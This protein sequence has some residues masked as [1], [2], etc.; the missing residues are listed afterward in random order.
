M[1]FSKKVLNGCRNVRRRRGELSDIGIAVKK[2]LDSI[3]GVI[4][5][6]AIMYDSQLPAT[7]SLS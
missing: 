1:I 2:H 3:V 7:T 6:R 4:V 5:W